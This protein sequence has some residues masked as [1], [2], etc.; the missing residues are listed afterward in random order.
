MPT[1]AAPPSRCQ[2]SMGIGVVGFGELL[3]LHQARLV[4]IIKYL[5]LWPH[6]GPHRKVRS[7]GSCRHSQD[8]GVCSEVEAMPLRTP[9]SYTLDWP[10]IIP[11]LSCGRSHRKD[12]TSLPWKGWW[13]VPLP[14]FRSS[15]P[16]GCP[17]SRQLPAPFKAKCP[18]GC[19]PP[20]SAS[21]MLVK[22]ANW[23]I[24]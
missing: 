23:Q 4:V 2:D 5:P 24:G 14:L 6:T 19:P 3:L 1:E 17:A 7:C 22:T 13:Y 20:M 11:S 21:P 10:E 18:Q 16:L 9:A 12:D 15:V 8:L